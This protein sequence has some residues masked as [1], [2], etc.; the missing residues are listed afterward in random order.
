MKVALYIEDGVQQLV[1]TPENDHERGAL[2][3]L[4][5]DKYALSIKRGEFYECRGGWNRH[6]TG[7]N[8]T[9]LVL[10]RKEAKP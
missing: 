1:M 6:G 4:H 8:S 7:D 9:M 10:R 2:A 5:E 3:L